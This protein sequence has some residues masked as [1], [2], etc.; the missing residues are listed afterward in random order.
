MEVRALEAF[1]VPILVIVQM[2]VLLVYVLYI[3]EVF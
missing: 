3:V 1:L 2:V